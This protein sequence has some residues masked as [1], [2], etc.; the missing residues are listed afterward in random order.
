MKSKS[1][2]INKIWDVW[3]PKNTD[4]FAEQLETVLRLSLEYRDKIQSLSNDS[5]RTKIR[6]INLTDKVT[7]LEYKINTERSK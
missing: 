7:D 1:K 6:L 5:N 3:F 2:I 4:K